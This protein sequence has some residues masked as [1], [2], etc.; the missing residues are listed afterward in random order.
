M[1]ER[2]AGWF[3][4]LTPPSEYAAEA[5]EALGLLE[6]HAGGPVRTIL[7]LGSG[8]G[9]MASHLSGRL[10]MTL[11]DLSP[12]ML[13]VSR[14]INP[15][16]EH[17][18]GDMRSVR[19]GRT[20]DAVIIHDA[21][22]YMTSGSDLRDALAT[23]FTHLR[24]GGAAIFL[25]DWVLDTYQPRTEHGGT[26]EGRRGLRYLEWDRPRE[27]DGHTV[28][29]DYV[30]VTRDGDEVSVY[31]DVHTL[32][33]FERATWLRS[34]EEVGFEPHRVVGSEGYDIFIGH[35]PGATVGR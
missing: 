14:T 6:A 34:L 31:H 17:L 29:T 9:N 3:H 11:V 33:I 4:L 7:E 15:C 23:A 19:L 10:D 5:V 27:P 20:F 8:G 25:P 18:V 24:P 26:D 22:V 28:L 13:D 30:I 1:Y 32:G 21:I 12:A 2:L 35:R 16:A